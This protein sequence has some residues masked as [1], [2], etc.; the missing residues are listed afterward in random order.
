M[1]IKG[2]I[3]ISSSSLCSANPLFRRLL[4]RERFYSRHEIDRATL[5]CLGDIFYTHFLPSGSNSTITD[6]GRNR[7]PPLLQDRAG[8]SALTLNS[9][10]HHHATVH[11]SIQF[12]VLHS[13]GPTTAAYR[14]DRILPSDCCPMCLHTFGVACN[15]LQILGSLN[16]SAGDSRLPL[17]ASILSEATARGNVT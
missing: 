15:L 4:L 14:H 10:S 9:G 7:Q 16:T 17:L 2:C 12:H 11:S 6:A 3:L 8:S 5:R 13:P 1:C